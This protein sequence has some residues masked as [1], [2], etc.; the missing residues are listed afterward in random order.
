MTYIF[1]HDSVG[2]G[3]DG[4]THQPVETVSGL[5]VIPGLDVIR[6]GDAEETAG[7]FMA[8]MSRTDGP[9]VLVLTRQTIPLMNELSVDDRRIGV[10]RGAYIAKKETSALHTILLATGSE[11]QHAI[12]AAAELGDGV[13]VVS[14]PCFERFDR[15]SPDYIESILPSSCTKRV[16]IEAGV[17]G[18]WWKY[19]GLQGKV[20]AIDRFGISAPGNVVTQ[21]LGMTKDNVVAAAR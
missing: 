7:A 1:T 16:A 18:L 15:Q 14:M 4:P 9:T 8:A 6:P 3:E 19:V 13:R 17:G 2:V 12:A 20:I 10:M 5:R 21:E 11:L